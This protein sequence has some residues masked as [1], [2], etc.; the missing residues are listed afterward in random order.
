MSGEKKPQ[1]LAEFFFGSD[2]NIIIISISSSISVVDQQSE[3][4]EA[5]LR[6]VFLSFNSQ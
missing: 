1:S 6:A 2:I 5:I 3:R 4:S